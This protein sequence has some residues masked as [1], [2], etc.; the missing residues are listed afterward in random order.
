MFLDQE[1]KSIGE[2]KNRVSICCDLHRRL[3]D[4]EIQEIR[5]GTRRTLSTLTLGLAVAE[6]VLGFFREE[7]SRRR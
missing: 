4:I 7:K 2:A 5:L 3:V 1:L 6:Q